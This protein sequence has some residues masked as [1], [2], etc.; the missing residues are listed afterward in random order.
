MRTLKDRDTAVKVNRFRLD[1]ALDDAKALQALGDRVSALWNAANYTCR[2]AFLAKTGVP[3]YP[4][5]YR[6]FRSQPN[7]RALPSDIAQETLKKLREAWSSFFGLLKLW[8]AGELEECPGLPKYRKD[9]RAG[10]R[11]ID[12]VPIT[13]ERSYRVTG[14]HVEVTMPRDLRQT[15][16][17]VPY[18]G[19][20]RY[21][22]AGRRAEILYDAAR[23]RWYFLYTV[24]ST[25][26]SARPGTVA[27]I[28]LGVRILAS[29][30]IAGV[31]QAYHY[32]GR[33]VLK[34]WEYWNR[35]IVRHQ[36][37]L[38]HRHKK[39][40][41]RLKQLYAHRRTRLQHAWDAM[42]KAIAGVCRR[43]TVGRVLIGWPKGILEDVKASRTWN[44]RLH[45]FWSFDKVAARLAL[46][47]QRRGIQVEHVGERGTS[48]HCPQCGSARVMRRPR[49]VLRCRDC[50]TTLHADQ[51]GSRNMIRQRYP[52]IWDGVEATPAPN[53]RR[54]DKHRWVNAYNPATCVADP[55]AA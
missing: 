15:R 4:A 3:S 5:L 21:R 55:L 14:R 48:S 49:S 7:Y 17:V 23:Q 11:P 40:S 44:G 32:A 31:P 8:K 25:V 2:Q 36:Q 9:R 12:F 33:D 29:L 39:T 19:T 20:M 35:Q 27:G 41:R 16:L 51:A 1:P 24:H 6:A 42:S 10:T 37:E 46:A 30:S 53:T 43:H 45:A 28:D 52:D 13:C 18:R 34:D 38:A 22:G 47:L 54:W 50:H 26:P